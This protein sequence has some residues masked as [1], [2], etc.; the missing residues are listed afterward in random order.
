ML[1]I[2]TLQMVLANTFFDGGLTVAG[3]AMFAG[4]LA[5]VMAI[6]KSTFKALVVALPITIMF[7]GLGVLST[8]LT[9]VL[10]IIIVLGLSLTASKVGFGR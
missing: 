1:S 2:S 5:V 8:D 9:I 3:L 4:V 10:V 6:T 7:S